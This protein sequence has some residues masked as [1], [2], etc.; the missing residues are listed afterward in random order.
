DL[1]AIASALLLIGM[2]FVYGMTGKLDITEIANVLAHCN[3]AGLQQQCLL[4]YL[5]MMIATFLF[6]LGAFPFL[7]CLPDVYQGAPNA[8]ANI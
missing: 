7:M 2:S 3:F 1:G 6:K 5:V 8:V 4:V